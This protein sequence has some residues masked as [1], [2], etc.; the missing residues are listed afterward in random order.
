MLVFCYKEFK[1]FFKG[2]VEVI[3]ILR[4]VWNI[5]VEEVIGVDNYLVLQN[6]NGEYYLNGYWFIQWFGDYNI[7]GMVVRYNW[8]GNRDLFD[9]VGFIIELL[10]IM[11]V[12]LFFLNFI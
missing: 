12:W 5:W 7:V 3:V 8:F 6:D 2:Y 11:V 10:Y 9:V 4:N 1:G